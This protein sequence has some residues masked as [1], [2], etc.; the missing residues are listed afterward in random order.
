VIDRL[1]PGPARD[2]LEWILTGLDGTPGW[3]TNVAEVLAPPFLA[4]IS[5]ETFRARFR[6]RSEKYA[7][8]QL[9]G[10]DLG[11]TTAQA[12]LRDRDGQLRVLHCTVEAEPPHRITTTWMSRW[13]PEFTAPPL[14]ADFAGS[15]LPRTGQ[16]LIVF[17]GVPGTGKSSLADALGRELRIPVFAVDWLL[18]ALTPFG[19]RHQPELLESGYELLTTLAYRQLQLGQSAILDAPVEEAEVRGRWRSLAAAAGAGL[20]VITCVCS[21]PQVHQDRLQDRSRA[22]PG[23]HEGGD[24]RNVRRRLAT[25]RPWEESGLTVDAVRPVA[26]NLAAAL[27]FLRQ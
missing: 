24:W 11:E 14:P 4:A 12:R 2:R 22:I 13:V 18:G 3:G 5:E 27:D 21:D 19:G 15:E 8:L 10:V 16:R 17:S 7:P 25:F 9:V 6:Q 26:A 1:L 23:W 20:D